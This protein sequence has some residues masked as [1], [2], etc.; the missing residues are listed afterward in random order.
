MDNNLEFIYRS[1]PFK[2]RN[3][4]EYDLSNVLDIFVDPTESLNT[5]FDYENA[6][7]KGR[8]GTGK[9]MYL[10]AN[11]AFFLYNI[12]PSM[13]IES[14]LI[15]PIYIKLSDFQHISLPEDIYK[16]IVLRII[17]EMTSVYIHISDAKKMSDIHKGVQ[18]LPFSSLKV[19]T[20][21]KSVYEEILKL[22]SDEYTQ[23]IKTEL[24]LGAKLK[25]Q[26]FEFLADRKKSTEIE[27][28]TKRFPSISDIDNV[29]S[30]LLSGHE[31]K[32][33]LLFDEAGSLNKSFFN[34]ESDSSYFEILM[35]QLRTSNY[36]R[37]KIAVYPQSYS[38]ILTETRYGDIY[39]LEED[40][41]SDRG[42]EN[43][44]HR[45]I[46]LIER[47]LSSSVNRE[48]KFEKIYEIMPEEGTDAVEQLI[49]ASMGNMRRFVQL[50]DQTMNAAFN[51]NKGKDKIKLHH[52]ITA[53]KNH[54]ESM[55][56]L[57]SEQDQNF[58]SSIVKAC[59]YRQAYKFKF[60]NKAGAL[61]KYISKSSEANILRVIETGTGRRS[62]TY[63]FDY[64]YCVYSSLATHFVKGTEKIDRSRSRMNGD[65]IQRVTTLSDEQ[66]EHSN[67]PGKIGGKVIFFKNDK[68]FLADD[69]GTEYF[70][71]SNYIIESDREKRIINGNRVRFYP[72]QLDDLKIATEIEIL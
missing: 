68:G 70:W 38:D 51:D 58:L 10:R 24:G 47:Y 25:N 54:G 11:H 22:S 50:L 61:Y 28:K 12:I 45:A 65:W 8:M 23:K 30:E 17:A 21:L 42:F 56:D 16:E 60:P 67:L 27:F 71:S 3:A 57:F 66:L 59:R 72:S 39:H 18:A 52:A 15:F 32:I 31:G 48:C 14:P 7:I 5:P 33:L 64:A 41:V 37:T 35:N 49:N 9:T 40:I 44:Y 29:F 19:D 2:V 63:A 20:G 55:E 53:L 13:L 62:S 4:D 1:R 46:E 43:F 36:I 26:F 6:I 69:N 34:Q